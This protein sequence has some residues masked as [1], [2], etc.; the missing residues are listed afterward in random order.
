MAQHQH[1]AASAGGGGGNG[2]FF[3]AFSGPSGPGSASG[4]RFDDDDSDT[5]D[6]FALRA[7][8]EEARERSR[9]K[10]VS[11][12]RKPSAEDELELAS[13]RSSFASNASSSHMPAHFSYAFNS[14]GGHSSKRSMLTSTSSA[15]YIEASTPDVKKPKKSKK[16][17]PKSSKRAADD[18]HH[19]QM[20][21]QRGSLPALD[22]RRGSVESSHVSNRSHNGDAYGYHPPGSPSRSNKSGT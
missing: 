8:E 21:Q 19:V 22:A 5:T 10:L 2:M 3:G 9:V 6:G 13:Y 11:S 7:A 1:A 17:R 15:S 16:A 18:E 12:R 14:G 4:A 20:Q